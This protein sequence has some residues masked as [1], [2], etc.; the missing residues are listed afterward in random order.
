MSAQA[1]AA[2]HVDRWTRLQDA[3]LTGHA[4]RLNVGLHLLSTPLGIFAALSLAAHLGRTVPIAVAVLAV[5][6][7]S[8]FLPARLALVHAIIAAVLVAASLMV[9]VPVAWGL[10]LVGAAWLLQNLAHVVSSEATYASDYHDRPGAAL[11]FAEHVLFLLPLVLAATPRARGPLIGAIVPRRALLATRLEDAEDRGALRILR[12]WAEQ[13]TPADGH[14]THWWTSDL[15][16]PARDACRRIAGSAAIE[17]MLRARHGPSARIRIVDG[18]N[19]VYVAGP[20]RETSSDRV[21]YVPHIDG[22]FAVFPGA[23]LYRC[24][25]ALTPNRRI[26]THFPLERAGTEAA[27]VV[28]DEAEVVAFDYHRTPHYISSE[29][30]EIASVPRINLKL[31]YIVSPPRLA[32]WADALA[33]LSTAYNTRARDLFLETLVPRRRAS[34]LAARAVVWQ[35]HLWQ[36][37]A[38]LLG[39]RNI[40]AV[41]LLW[42]LSLAVGSAWPLVVGGSFA[43]YLLYLATFESRRDVSFGI[44]KR[45]ALFWKTLSSAILG[46]LYLIHFEFDPVS[47]GLIAFGFGLAALATDALGVDRTFF[48]AELGVCPA[49]R[50]ERFPYGAIPHPMILGSVVG[51]IGVAAL[52]PLRAAWPWLIPA[53]VAFYLAHLVQEMLDLHVHEDAVAISGPGPAPLCGLE[54]EAGPEPAEGAR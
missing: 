37:I 33:S 34:R 27:S 48:G 40:F 9:S 51:L 30:G 43:H 18:M 45:D 52:D 1:A 16:A 20:D 15:G 24:M 49:A 3:F 4:T 12:R 14:T 5:G 29:P 50:V 6:L 32:R 10:G 7:T 39:H 23:T 53:H 2:G 42:A 47:L 46:L 31:H 26:R 13:R 35:T 17:S 11:R 54:P 21:F 28:L 25:V 44:F 22:P 19:E 8:L 38:R 41:A 36:Q